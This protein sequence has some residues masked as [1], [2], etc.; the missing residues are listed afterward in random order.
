MLSIAPYWMGDV[1]ALEVPTALLIV[2]ERDLIVCTRAVPVGGV[3]EN[4]NGTVTVNCPPNPTDAVLSNQAAAAWVRS[5]GCVAASVKPA[6]AVNCT[7]RVVNDR[8]VE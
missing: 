5:K 2:A 3:P 8:V 7:F 1:T 4:V 6:A